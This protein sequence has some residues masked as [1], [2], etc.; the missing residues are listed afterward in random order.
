LLSLGK[1][2][3]LLLSQLFDDLHSVTGWIVGIWIVH[4]EV[5]NGN[6]G[7]GAVAWYEIHSVSID[8]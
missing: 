8:E 7:G 4:G 3:Q 5:A 2:R 1:Q 6:L